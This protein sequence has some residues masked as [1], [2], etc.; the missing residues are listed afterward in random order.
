MDD[1]LVLIKPCDIPS[2]LRKFNSFDKNLTFTVDAFE[3]ERV[4][5]L[6]LEISKSGIDVF[7][8]S[9]DTG[10]YKGSIPI[11]IV[12]NRGL[13]KQLGLKP[14]FYLATLLARTD[15]KV[16]YLFAANFFA[17]QF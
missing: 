6:D 5:F 8:K 1:T 15:K 3:N 4:H 12:S 13:V 10:Q 2:V 16:T 7:R 9:T 14:V 17:S 11:F